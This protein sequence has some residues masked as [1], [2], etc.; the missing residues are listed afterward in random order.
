MSFSLDDLPVRIVAAPM[1]G[2]P[3]TPALVAAVA[4]AGGLGF[5]AGARKKPEI[6]AEEIREVRRTSTRPFGVNLFLPQPPVET[7]AALAA[8]LREMQAEADRYG[9]S[10]PEPDPAHDD[11]WAAKIDVLVADPVP[12]VSFTFGLPPRS[13]VQRLRHAG[14]GVVAT[15]TSVPEARAADALGVDALCVQGPQAGGH[16]G[17]HDRDAEPDQ[18]PLLELLAAVRAVTSLP[19]IA[20][21]GLSAGLDVA[22]VLGVGAGAA[23]LGTAYLRTPEAGTKPLHKAALA[24]PRFDRTVVTRA[25]SGR[26]ARGLPNR[27][28]ADHDSSAP[29]AFPL[30]D[31]VTA[32]LRAAAARHGDAQAMSLWAGTGHALATEEPARD[33]TTRLWHEA[34]SA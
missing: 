28:V 16:R 33:V 9:V 26:Y 2:G 10:L 3:S 25:F 6:M 4:R 31:L 18:T 27:F 12:V 30:L 19:L 29:P 7:S 23:Q 11:H 5:L 15:V 32:P 22:A 14:S 13:V 1:A 20:A 21:G 24:D 8:Y 34:G 17:T